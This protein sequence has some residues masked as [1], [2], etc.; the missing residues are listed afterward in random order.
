[1][2]RILRILKYHL[3]VFSIIIIITLIFINFLNAEITQKDTIDLDQ[4]KQVNDDNKAQLETDKENIEDLK[5]EIEDL[6][7]DIS[8]LKTQIKILNALDISGFFDVSISNYKNKPNIFSLGNFESFIKPPSRMVQSTTVISGLY[9]F[10]SIFQHL[11]LNA[12][13]NY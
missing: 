3:F 10:Y 2:N 8:I 11:T 4:N 9:I 5:D 6:E 13:C 12:G 1:M 7:E